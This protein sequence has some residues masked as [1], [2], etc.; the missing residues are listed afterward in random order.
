MSQENIELVR[1]QIGEDD[2]AQV[3]RDDAL[4][5]ARR[6][7]I[8]EGFDE[9]FEFVV[10][11]P[12]E[13]VSGRGFADFRAQFLDWME[14]FETYEPNI[15]EIIDLGDRVVVLGKD[16]GRIKGADRD[17][18][19]PKGLVLYRFASGKVAQIEY[20]FDRTAGLRAAGL[21]G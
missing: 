15:E 1:R 20:F 7:A 5:A 8:E 2:L 10:H 13:P 4:W 11:V 19:G 3:I 21:P 6:A 17:V 9:D 14:P 16:R 18:D 12:G